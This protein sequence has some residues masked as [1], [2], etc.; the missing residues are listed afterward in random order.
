MYINE[1]ITRTFSNTSGETLHYFENT[2]NDS[3]AGSHTVSRNDVLFYID[4]KYNMIKMIINVCKTKSAFIKCVE[5][6]FYM[7]S[8]VY[9]L[10]WIEDLLVG[11]KKYNRL[12]GNIIRYN[13]IGQKKQKIQHDEMGCDIYFTPR[14][15]TE[16][17]NRDVVVFDS[18]CV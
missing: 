6:T 7:E 4:P 5:K 11:M 1:G 16:N 15:I 14:Y 8:M 17:I 10:L 9:I 12:K 18:T 3:H 2:R 13:R